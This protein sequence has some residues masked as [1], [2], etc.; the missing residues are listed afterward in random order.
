[1]ASDLFVAPAPGVSRLRPALLLGGWFLL[2]GVQ[3]GLI[4]LRPPHPHSNT[5]ACGLLA[6][7]AVVMALLSVLLV[8]R[9]GQSFFIVMVVGAI[10]LC[11]AGTAVSVAGQGQM[12]S[13]LFLAIVGVLVGYFLP[14]QVVLPLLAVM[15]VGY[16]LALAAQPLLESMTYAVVIECLIAAV[17]LTVNNLS[18]HLRE[19]AVH[20]PLTG[21]FNRRGLEGAARQLHELDERLHQPTVVVEI[22]LD[23][24]KDFND[25]Y[26]H[27]AGDDLLVSTVRDW[28]HQLRR[29]DV[30]ARTG[31]DEFVLVL[32]NTDAVQAEELLIRLRACN[33]TK[34]TAGVTV[35]EPSE[36]LSGAI[37]HADTELYAHKHSRR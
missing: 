6:V 7:Y 23:G 15:L 33:A 12:M 3:L 31:G 34:W 25:R 29:S 28:L 2:G 32:P 30:L 18:E 21:V 24:F 5:V 22:D 36:R 9:R 14:R 17:T 8:S 11:F 26:G 19:Q 37:L 1:M 13:G 16:A 20:D 27:P 4:A 10:L 35:W